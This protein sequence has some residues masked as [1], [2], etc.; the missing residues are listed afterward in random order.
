MT[1]SV[2]DVLRLS[3]TATSVFSAMSN[4]NDLLSQNVCQCLDQGRTLNRGPHIEWL[5]LILATKFSLNGILKV[6]ES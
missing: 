4:P 2:T 6:F 1:S 3:P 5:T